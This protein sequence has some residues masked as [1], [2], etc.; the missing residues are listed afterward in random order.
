MSHSTNM[1]M[2]DRVV[3][4]FADHPEEQLTADDIATK[5]DTQRKNVHTQLQL[6]VKAG[7]LL[8][9]KDDEHGYIYTAG[10]S[11][12][13]PASLLPQLH[14]AAPGSTKQP[15]QPKADVDLRTLPVDTD[16]P[17]PSL[18]RAPQHA[19]EALDRLTQPGHS[20]GVPLEARGISALRKTITERHQ[21]GTHR[22]VVRTLPTEIRIWRTA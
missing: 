3:S 2:P 12:A 14:A 19:P 5:F 8:R 10:P 21:A 16:I 4:F 7:R 20:F 9:T 18:Q 17:L 15:R 11:V 1:S 6:A 13:Q 22:Y